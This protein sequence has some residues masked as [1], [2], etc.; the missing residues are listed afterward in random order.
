MKKDN[1]VTIDMLE[2]ALQKLREEFCTVKIIVEDERPPKAPK[3]GLYGKKK[4]GQ[5]HDLRARMD[6]V[7]FDLLE[8]EADRDFTSNVS[9]CLD[10]IL[11]HRYGK[12]ELS[13]QLIEPVIEPVEGNQDSE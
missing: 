7:I 4:L 1:L 12:P 13:F 10:Y 5:R 11:W 9:A 8:Q 3:A 2:E 6:K